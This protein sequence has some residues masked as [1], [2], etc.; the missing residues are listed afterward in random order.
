MY[1]LF[2]LYISLNQEHFEETKWSQIYHFNT[3]KDNFVLYNY[4]TYYTVLYN[5]TL[6]MTDMSIVIKLKM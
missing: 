3:Q 1:L 2:I 5:D 4:N 6:D